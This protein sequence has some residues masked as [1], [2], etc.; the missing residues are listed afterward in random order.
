M[1]WRSAGGRTSCP[2]QRTK[3]ADN[4]RTGG[5]Q[6]RALAADPALP[7][8]VHEE[9]HAMYGTVDV[10][11]NSAAATH[12]AGRQV[13]VRASRDGD[14]V[15]IRARCEEGSC[16]MVR[17]APLASNAAASSRPFCCTP[18]REGLQV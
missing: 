18:Q 4:T 6:V 12:W 11:V 2:A 8:R 14:A 9:L 7:E 1:S 15:T 16:R 3:L 17:S 10:V 5:G 13:T